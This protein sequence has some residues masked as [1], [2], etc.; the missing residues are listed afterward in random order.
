MKPCT[1]NAKK[2]NCR[3]RSLIAGYKAK[4]HKHYNNTT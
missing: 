2:N 1:H 3:P 4:K